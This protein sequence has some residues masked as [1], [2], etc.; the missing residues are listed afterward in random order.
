MSAAWSPPSGVVAVARISVHSKQR[1][2]RFPG[3]GGQDGFSG[4]TAP[5]PPAP[6][7]YGVLSLTATR[8]PWEASVQARYLPASPLPSTTTSYS[9]GSAMIILPAACVGPVA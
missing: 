6:L 2:N 5:Q 1:T 7:S 3:R 8:L 4:Y 9:S